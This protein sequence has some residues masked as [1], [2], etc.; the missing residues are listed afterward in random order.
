MAAA[1]SSSWNV[2]P[3]SFSVTGKDHRSLPQVPIVDHMEEVVA[4]SG[5]LLNYSTWRSPVHAA[6]IGQ[7]RL[8]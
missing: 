1:R 4:A 6:G 3:Y 7:E 5:P 2:S 8:L